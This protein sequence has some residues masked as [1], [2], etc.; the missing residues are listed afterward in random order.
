MNTRIIHA[1]VSSGHTGTTTYPMSNMRSASSRTTKAMSSS[2]SDRDS[3]RSSTRPAAITARWARGYG[4]NR[5]DGGVD[6]SC[7]R[8]CEVADAADVCEYVSETHCDG[9]ELYSRVPTTMST[10]L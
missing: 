9:G 6:D 5:A 2:L 10:P 8:E 3:S 4:H 1:S 7:R